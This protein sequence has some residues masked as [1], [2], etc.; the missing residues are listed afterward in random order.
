MQRGKYVLHV[1]HRRSL[2]SVHLFF[3][4]LVPQVQH[5]AEVVDACHL[6]D[7]HRDLSALGYYLIVVEIVQ[8][9]FRRR[10]A[11][12]KSTQRLGAK[13]TMDPE[14]ITSIAKKRF[15]GM[16]LTS[17]LAPLIREGKSLFPSQ[18][19][20]QEATRVPLRIRHQ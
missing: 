4:S 3:F 7:P 5:C 2:D 6:L 8:M 17:H 13:N 11:P 9:S 15:R 12:R 14:K 20:K 19:E 1:L 18:P 10:L 16:K